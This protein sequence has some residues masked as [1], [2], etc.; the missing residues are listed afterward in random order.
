[1]FM[2]LFDDAH[3]TDAI[4]VHGVVRVDDD[5]PWAAHDEYACDD[6]FGGGDVS[7]VRV[8][9]V[10]VAQCVSHS[11][12]VLM[13]IYLTMC[14]VMYARMYMAIIFTMLML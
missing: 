2:S 13:W 1:M 14:L 6:T 11:A 10:F 8:I 5:A 12:M 9:G 7:C 3:T 4:D